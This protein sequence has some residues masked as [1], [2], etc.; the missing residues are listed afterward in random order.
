MTLEMTLHRLAMIRARPLTAPNRDQTVTILELVYKLEI[1]KKSE[2]NLL[3]IVNGGT[4][5]LFQKFF[6]LSNFEKN[7]HLV[8]YEK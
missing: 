4:Q 7:G 1:C 2:K 6:K 8:W 3:E 5:T